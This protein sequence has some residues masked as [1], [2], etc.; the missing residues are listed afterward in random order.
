MVNSYEVALLYAR[1]DE[2]MVSSLLESE[3]WQVYIDPLSMD[4]IPDFP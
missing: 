3:A 1:P 4:I 2:A